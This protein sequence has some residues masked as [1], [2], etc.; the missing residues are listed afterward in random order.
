MAKGR[1]QVN[2]KKNDITPGSRKTS[3]PKSVDLAVDK[4]AADKQT[5]NNQTHCVECQCAVTEDTRALNCERCFKLRKCIGCIG[6]R[7]STYDDLISEAGKELHW[8]CDHCQCKPANENSDKLDNLIKLVEALVIR[9]TAMEDKMKS[10]ADVA[11]QLQSKLDILDTRMTCTEIR[12]DRVNDLDA[13]MASVEAHL[14][15]VHD[16][17]GVSTELQK[18]VQH[19]INK[20]ITEDRDSENRKKNVI[21]YRVPEVI[22]DNAADRKDSDMTFVTELLESVFGIKPEDQNIVRMFR[23]GRRDD[24][25]TTSRPLLVAFNDISVKEAVWSNLRNLKEATA[26]FKGISVAHD[27]TP[28]QRDE[29]KKLLHQAKQEHESTSTDGPENYWFR[30]VGYGNKLKVI[31]RRKQN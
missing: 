3:K 20:Q 21:I 17:Q 14:N 1:S 28:A 26:R 19:E 6:L 15:K 31:K 18:S 9:V 25:S 16:T 2:S 10:D 5:T 22:A 12:L 11:I 27:M 29:I 7:A 13:R 8:Y 23:L 4:H 24:T 30:V